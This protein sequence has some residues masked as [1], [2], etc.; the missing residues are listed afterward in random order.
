MHK[1]SKEYQAYIGSVEWF[2]LCS[3]LK[4]ERGNHCDRCGRYYPFLEVHHVTY[5]RLGHEKD[6]DLRVLCHD[7]HTV[8]DYE[9]REKKQDTQEKRFQSW[10]ITVYGKTWRQRMTEDKGRNEYKAFIN[11]VK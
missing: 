8:E 5:A 1:H 2:K 4:Q 6:S 9:Y 11:R 3:R 10:M 7:C